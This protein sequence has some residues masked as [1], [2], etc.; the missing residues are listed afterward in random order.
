[1]KD[2]VHHAVLLRV[3][4]QSAQA[5]REVRDALEAGGCRGGR[6]ATWLA[7]AWQQKLCE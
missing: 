3:L 1:M 5:T 7:T 4:R 6:C 2:F